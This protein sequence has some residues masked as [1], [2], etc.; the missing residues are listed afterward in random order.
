MKTHRSLRKLV[1]KS[2]SYQLPPLHVQRWR[3]ESCNPEW[4]N[5]SAA[6][7]QSK[8]MQDASNTLKWNYLIRGQIGLTSDCCGCSSHRHNSRDITQEPEFT[9][10]RLELKTGRM[11]Q[12]V[13]FNTAIQWNY[14]KI[15]LFASIYPS[16]HPHKL[17]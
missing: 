5:N 16:T 15:S 14:A 4:I 8:S 2:V 11:L 3:K 12:A 1:T 7:G 13:S 17:A 10:A 9:P 6:V